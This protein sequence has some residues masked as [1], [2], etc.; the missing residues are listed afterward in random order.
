MKLFVL[1]LVVGNTYLN[2]AGEQVKIVGRGFE[3]ISRFT[4][5]GCKYHQVNKRTECTFYDENGKHNVRP[6]DRDLVR[7]I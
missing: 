5:E 1:I 2:G 3:G 6:S 7:G 4:Y